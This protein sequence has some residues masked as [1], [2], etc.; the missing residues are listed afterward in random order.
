MNEFDARFLFFIALLLLNSFTILLLFFTHATKLFAFFS[1]FLMIASGLVISNLA[2]D[3]SNHI[4]FLEFADGRNMSLLKFFFTCVQE[5]APYVFAGVGG[6]IIVMTFK[7]L[8]T[9]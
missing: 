3:F 7:P 5:V 4:A 6:N 8:K 2:I 1:G 9:T